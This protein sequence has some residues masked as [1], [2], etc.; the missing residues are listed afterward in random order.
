[1]NTLLRDLLGKIDQAFTEYRVID[2]KSGDDTTSV[3]LFFSV[4]LVNSTQYKATN[5]S[6]WVSVFKDFYD[7]V[8]AYVKRAYINAVGRFYTER[9]VSRVDPHVTI[10]WGGESDMLDSGR[11]AIQKAALK[12]MALFGSAG[13][14]K[15]G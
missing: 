10:G 11:A 13:K 8:G 14:A 4:D 3:F 1:M 5:Q 12:F 9:D 15:E 6:A 7:I 2:K